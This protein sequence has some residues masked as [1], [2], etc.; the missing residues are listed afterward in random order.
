MMALSAVMLLLT[1]C[2][3]AT[4]QPR[5][6]A[7]SGVAE[8][9]TIDYPDELPLEALVDYVG[10]TLHVRVLYGDELN[11]QK[12][13]LRP[14][15][16]ELPKDRL[17]DLL[18]SV[19]RVRGL[20]L[21]PGDL[22]G[23]F[24]V[25]PI[26]TVQR[27]T[28]EIRD[29]PAEGGD[30]LGSSDRIVTQILRLRSGDTKS[31]APHVRSFMSSA[32]G[33]V[34]EVPEKGLLIVT[35]RESAVSRIMRLVEVIDARP[36]PITT[37]M[38]AVR[39]A[40]PAVLS[41]Q[42]TR[43]LSDRTKA[44]EEELAAV[45][46]TAGVVA[47]KLVVTG[48]QQQ[49]DDVL[50]LIE[51]FDVA[52]A[53]GQTMQTYTPRHTSASRIKSLIEGVLLK[54]PTKGSY[55]VSLFVDQAA[56]RLYVTAPTELH[57]A[58]EGLLMREDRL[59]LESSRP[60]RI[61]RP[62][63]RKASEIVDTLIQLL[64]ESTV[65]LLT[66]QT[67]E[68]DYASLESP[69]NPAPKGL[70]PPKP[71]AGATNTSG[72]EADRSARRI[73]GPD[74]V[75]T[76]DEHTNSIIAIGTPEFHTQLADL[77]EQLDARRPQVMIEM[78]LVGVTVTDS[79]SLGVE[80]KTRDMDGSTL[81]LL[82]SDF[83]LSS[84]DATTGQVA[85]SPGVGINGALM[86][87]DDFAIVMQ[88]LA[89]HGNSRVLATPRL[90][91]SDNSEGTL[92]SVDEAPFTSVNASDT[93]AT[94][95]F[96]G[97]ESAGTTLTV[98]PHVAEGDYL[99]LEYSLNF[100]NFTGSSSITTAPPPRTTNS[101]SGQVEVPDGYTVVV[102]GLVVENESDSVDEIPVLGRIPLLGALFQNSAASKSQ[103]RVYAFIR[104]V[105]LRDDQF[106]DLKFITERDLEAAELVNK[107]FP[108]DRLMWMR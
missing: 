41:G 104:P 27:V 94:T 17:L 11:N 4:A 76:E 108:P 49:M 86:R 59:S 48:P 53:A 36:Q 38:V 16:I 25:I 54:D 23:Y 62:C 26:E 97:F 28:G 63:N 32:K 78:M 70:V 60:L 98:T 102:G 95:S 96:G 43:I 81:G 34:V 45:S 47:D 35:D 9:V 68:A 89:T 64:E 40:N 61:Y 74:W 103:T 3:G 30:E 22:P 8:M 66:G 105:V 21:V 51:R 85:L 90:L 19:L 2:A 13:T 37:E 69:P 73:A 24:R 80:I 83:G 107:D 65:S 82:F 20:A 10:Q 7:V 91:V 52:P 29:G 72:D 100:S 44:G 88:A 106:K 75:L 5:D 92:R 14:G 101:F 67:T 33:S 6:T 12:V 46:V 1:F 99:S 50:Q 55:G 77:I 31:V 79:V 71:P 42:V 84:F 15:T 57:A 58:I 56:N 93:V 18:R 39:N 87:P